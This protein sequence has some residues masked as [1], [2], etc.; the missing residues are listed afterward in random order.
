M[1]VCEDSE[2]GEGRVG[3]CR[4]AGGRQVRG[5]A[6]CTEREMFK[7][8]LEQ[9]RR[10]CKLSLALINGRQCTSESGEADFCRKNNYLNLR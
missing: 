5:S 3:P 9:K 1:G 10:L 6:A 8:L 7:N 2:N 4:E